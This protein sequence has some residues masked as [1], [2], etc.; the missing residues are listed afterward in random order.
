MAFSRSLPRAP[1]TSYRELCGAGRRRARGSG[2]R[3]CRAPTAR[4]STPSVDY[5]EL[6][7]LADATR[8]LQAAGLQEADSTA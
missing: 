4:R 2:W 5:R 6:A 3:A 7:A 8:A 1:G